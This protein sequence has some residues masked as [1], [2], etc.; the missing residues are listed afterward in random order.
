MEQRK[1]RFETLQVHA[2]Y[3]PEPTTQAC[4]VPIYQTSAYHFK[5]S[6]HGANLFAL[7]EFGNIYTRL[8]NPTTDVFEQRMA[9][10]EGGVAAL[11]VA[12][13]HSAELIALTNI[14]K[15]GDN[16]VSSPYLYGGSYNM[17]KTSLA[18]FGIECR[19]ANGL[20][21]VDFEMLID[22]NTK[23]I[24][25]ESIGNSNFSIPDFEALA[26][27]AHGY[28]IPLIVD[29]TFGAAGYL[30]RPIEHGADIVVESA[31]KWVCGHGTSMGGVIIDAGRFD[32]G[33]GKFPLISEPSQSYHGMNLW[34]TFGSIAFIIKC[35]VEGVRDLG[36]CISPFNS[37]MMIQGLE[38]LS[39]RVEREAQN[40]LSLA[41][42]FEKHPQVAE[43][44]Y[45]GLEGDKYHDMAKKYLR[46]GFGCVLSVVLKGSKEQSVRFVESLQVVSHLA[47]VGDTKTLIIQPAATTH[48]QLSPEA[49]KGAGIQP[50]TLRISVGIEHI[51]DLIEDFDKAFEAA[52]D[53]AVK[54]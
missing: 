41:R 44:A 47:N 33:S 13:G 10:L 9:A 40:A 29:N 26:E 3:T 6:E 34:E 4:A 24:Y 7:K 39:L 16:F 50:T 12:S 35:R 8:M 32:W 2:G 49:L 38:T 53:G 46:N 25:V 18:N 22:H 19:F 45:S 15:Q 48:Q 1:F 37:F 31:T 11:A 27:L 20:D 14:M 51:D 42:Y 23:A 36:P 28:G 17:F 54:Q 5:S 21:P 30:C 43:V 52:F